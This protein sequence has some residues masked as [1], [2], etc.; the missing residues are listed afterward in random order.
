MRSADEIGGHL[1]PRE[2]L[3]MRQSRTGVL[4][5]VLVSAI[6]VSSQQVAGG[7]SPPAGMVYAQPGQL[8][9][10]DGFRL[11]LYCMGSGSP[12]VVFDS[13]RRLRP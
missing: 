12:T 3:T 6:A 1:H 9:S 13:V 4:L 2:V 10:I 11:N 8:V 7:S 5:A